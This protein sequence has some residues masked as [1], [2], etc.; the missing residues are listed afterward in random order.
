MLTK[1][2]CALGVGPP[3]G[4]EAYAGGPNMLVYEGL[5]APVCEMV[6]GE[7]WGD[8]QAAGIRRQRC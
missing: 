1:L 4:I 2:L 5:V 3:P 6:S 7:G 8:V